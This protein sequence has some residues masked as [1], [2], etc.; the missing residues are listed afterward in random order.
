MV[1][2]LASGN[3]SGD[4]GLSVERRDRQRPLY[5][6]LPNDATDIS[7]TKKFLYIFL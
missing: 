2:E 4:G 3:E 6:V 7:C 5:R 1:W